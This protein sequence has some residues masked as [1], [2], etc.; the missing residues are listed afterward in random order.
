MTTPQAQKPVIVKGVDTKRYPQIIDIDRLIIDGVYEA[1]NGLDDSIPAIQASVGVAV[2]TGL[3]PSPYKA[4]QI[5]MPRRTGRINPANPTTAYRQMPVALTGVF[6]VDQPEYDADYIIAPLDD[7]RRLLEYDTDAASWLE[8]KA[9]PGYSPQRGRKGRGDRTA[10][11]RRSR[12]R[13]SASRHLPHDCSRE[14][15]HVPHA[16]VHSHH[17]LIQHSIDPESDGD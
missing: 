2:A 5:Y 12:P 7:V 3:R 10:G 1:D 11:F 16:G 9:A 14:M 4:A 17:S 6:R 13:A 15:G 8:I